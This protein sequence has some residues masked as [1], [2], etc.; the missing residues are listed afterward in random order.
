MQTTRAM[1]SRC[2]APRPSALPLLCSTMVRCHGPSAG[3]P[4]GR[5]CST[6]L[7]STAACMLA[8]TFSLACAEWAALELAGGNQFKALSVVAKGLKEAA[9]PARWVL[10]AGAA[11][12][13]CCDSRSMLQLAAP[14]LHQHAGRPPAAPLSVPL[15]PAGADAGRPAGWQV[16]VPAALG[17]RELR[18]Q[19]GALWRQQPGGR[20][21]YARSAG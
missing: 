18:Q 1:C 11:R 3:W 6:Q 21:P 19:D 12:S 4:M 5:S 15:Q 10:A 20:L 2:C 9:Q 7:A 17:Q 14:V 13:C 16:C 8:D